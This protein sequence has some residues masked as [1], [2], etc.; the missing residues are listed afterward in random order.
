MTRHRFHGHIAGLGTAEGTRVVLGRW[1]ASDLGAFADVMVERADGRRLLLAPDA[2]VAAFVAATYR[3]DEVLLGPV[4]VAVVGPV[5]R[6]AAGPLSAILHVG[7][8][9]ALGWL[10]RAQPAPLVGS[11][12]WARAVRP[13]AT[14]VLPGVSTV[15]TAGAGRREWYGASD[16]H[17]LAAA[18]VAWA[19]R[20]LGALRPVAPPTRFGFSSTPARPSVVRVV[21]TV[22]DRR[23]VPPEG[24]AG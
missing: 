24:R 3:F 2:D 1:L 22:E 6:V 10:L 9:S 21:S 14:A 23:A 13:V 4:D 19:G 17:L 11:L 18:R 16:Q 7:P 12:A 5:W 20:D 8:R 15:G